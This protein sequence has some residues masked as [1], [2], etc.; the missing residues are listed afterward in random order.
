[1]E[2]IVHFD[3]A[4]KQNFDEEDGDENKDELDLN[5]FKFLAD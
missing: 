4:G 1:L 2:V 3:E 5:D